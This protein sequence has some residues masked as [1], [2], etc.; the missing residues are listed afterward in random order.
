[1][2]RILVTGAGGSPSTN[3][4]RSLREMKEKVFIVGT[5]SSEFYVNRSEADITYISP[6][7]ENK[8]Y[9]DYLNWIIKKHKLEFIHIQ[10]DKEMEIVSRNRE[11]L[12]TKFYL[13]SKKTVDNCMNKYISF[14]KWDKNGLK[15][16][17]TYFINN[18][19]D[20][21]NVYK[22]LGSKIWIRGISGAGGK[23]SLAPKNIDQA[24]TW[25]DFHNGWGN[26]TASELLTPNSITWMSIWSNGKLIVA[27]G[28]KRLYWELGRISASG[29]TG[30]TGGG[31]T[32]NDET[33]DNIALKAI[34]SIDPKPNGIFSVDLTYDFSG[35]PNPTE[36]N[37][38]RFF[39]THYF[40]TKAGLNMPEI[41][42][43]LAY[44]EPLPKIKKRI[45]PLPP[46]L[47][48]I[49]GVDFL[50]ILTNEDK[51]ERDK[52]IMKDI[53]NKV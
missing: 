16:P 5:D 23:G 11:K 43:K 22:K 10:N 49:R 34:K 20:L 7:C 12:R 29:I 42:L 27:Q 13:P 1:M 31:V 14:E 44:K 24:K 8:K 6:S 30:I 48:W 26:F 45:N 40:F 39:T 3:F 37:I 2:K 19:N 53:L 18:F 17:K 50:P 4:I 36:I 33:V 52:K 47:V 35:V 46:G 15:V 38:G 21:K 25:I 51:I 41:Y 32:V 9:F 28:R